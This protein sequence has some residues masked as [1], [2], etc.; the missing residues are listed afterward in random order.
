MS[1]V[2]PTL[3]S[4]TAKEK[5]RTPR[6]ILSTEHNRGTL[7]EEISTMEE[8]HVFWG[9]PEIE[10]LELGST[11][12]LAHLADAISVIACRLDRKVSAPG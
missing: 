10:R 9:G 4:R 3:G 2:W 6:A 5:N 8:F 11:D 12:I 1:M 7:L